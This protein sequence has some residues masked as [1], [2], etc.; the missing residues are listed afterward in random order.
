MEGTSEGTERQEKLRCHQH[1]K[2]RGGNPSAVLWREVMRRIHDG[3]ENKDFNSCSGLTQ[4]TVCQDS[5]LLATEACT[6]DLRGNR[7]T[8][9]TVAADT[10]PTQTCWRLR[11]ATALSG[12]LFP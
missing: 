8:T 5:G 10:A 2:E 7:V 1:Q 11:A 6:H 9:V 12:G 4:V 3:L